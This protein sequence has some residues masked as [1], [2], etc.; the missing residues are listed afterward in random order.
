[1]SNSP[2]EISLLTELSDEQQEII[3][4]GQFGDSL[5]VL[6]GLS[7][8]K[9]FDPSIFGDSEEP[10]TQSDNGNCQRTEE[11]EGNTS[12]VRITCLKTERYP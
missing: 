6:S 3:T 7:R 8:L 11:E 2:I 5:R 12:V 1:M 4:G 9:I 10:S